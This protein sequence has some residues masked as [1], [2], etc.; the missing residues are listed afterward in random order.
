MEC[1]ADGVMLLL[2]QGSFSLNTL[3]VTLFC[4]FLIVRTNLCSSFSL[5]HKHLYTDV[6]GGNVGFNSFYFYPILLQISPF[7]SL[8]VLYSTEA[9]FRR[10]SRLLCLCCFSSE[11]HLDSGRR[12]CK[13]KRSQQWCQPAV[14]L[15]EPS[16]KREDLCSHPS[17]RR[18]LLSL[19]LLCLTLRVICV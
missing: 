6:N 10:V 14:R 16:L 1:P 7:Q 2:I 9:A 15:S 3:T 13:Q 11:S 8:C 4:R 5:S 12:S 19:D 18:R 17:E